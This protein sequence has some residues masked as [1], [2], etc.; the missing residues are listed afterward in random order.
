MN[1]TPIKEKMIPQREEALKRPTDP[2]GGGDR[3]G[4]FV[5]LTS[6]IALV[7][8]LSILLLSFVKPLEKPTD[9]S[10]DEPS[11]PAETDPPAHVAVTYPSSP[12]R[13]S[14]LLSGNGTTIDNSPLSADFAIL[15]SLSDYS[16]VA[17]LNADAKIYPASMT[18]IM[19]LIVAC[20][21][22]KDASVTLTVTDKT[23]EYCRK[24]Q[25]TVLVIDSFDR[26]TA[27]DMLYAVG[28]VSAADACI[29]LAEHIA[30]S[31][32]DFVALMNAKAKSLGLTKTNFANCTGLDD[33]NNYSTAREMATILAYALDNPFCREILS[34]DNKTVLGYYSKDGEE[35]TYDRQLYNT[36]RSRLSGA[37]YPE[38]LPAKLSCGF[39]LLGAKT[40]Y[41]DEGGFCLASFLEDSD[42]ELYITVTA[43]GDTA[44]TSITD[45]EK[46]LKKHG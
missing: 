1:Q 12:S 32:E 5:L 36:L 46:I 39:T 43:K 15:V 14:F 38:K 30:G 21:E 33:E 28:V 18:K 7:L 9:E 27:T 34:T 44:G 13:N 22:I 31:E 3:A 24:S 29:T 11:T 23:L 20:E 6:A 45:M 8:A 17:S 2:K 19:T 4:L 25:A 10:T 41:T 35:K 42:G 40:G 37:G 26:F 16:V